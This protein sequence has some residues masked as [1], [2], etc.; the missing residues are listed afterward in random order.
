MTRTN[1]SM[2]EPPTIP[3]ASDD[4]PMHGLDDM[5]SMA[6]LAACL[7]SAGAV[8]LLLAGGIAHH[9]YTQGRLDRLAADL[10]ALHTFTSCDAP[11]RPGDTTVI[12]IR[13]TPDQLATRCQ[14]ITNPKH[15]ERAF[16]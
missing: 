8:V 15:P 4:L 12:T 13:R 5:G 3:P 14:L 10:R 9:H 6:M 7:I 2:S 11:P 16:Q 1:R